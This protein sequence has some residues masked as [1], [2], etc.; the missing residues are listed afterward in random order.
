MKWMVRFFGGLVALLAAAAVTAVIVLK[1]MDFNAY[2][3]LIHDEV[4]ATT[5]R[6][7]TIVGNLSLDISLTPSLVVENVKLANAPWG[8]RADMVV[9][10]RLAAEVRLI[11]LLG[12]NVRINRLVLNGLDVLLEVNE[13][14][15]V[16]WDLAPA[17]KPASAP[18]APAIPLVDKVLLNNLDI[19]YHDA[20]NGTSLKVAVQSL[21]L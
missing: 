10:K 11:P 20:R 5:G 18:V 8:A 14:G 1:N 3:G 4:K 16:N 15:L 19:S 13:R 12:G 2:R 17:A 21:D 6:D 9:L 7:L